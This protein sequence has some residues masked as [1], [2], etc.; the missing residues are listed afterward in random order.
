MVARR[1]PSRLVI[2]VLIALFTI[3]TISVA[4][5]AHA[6]TY[7]QRVLAIRAAALMGYWALNETSG[8]LAM[9]L[10][11]N[12]NNGTYQGTTLNGA[13][14][15]DGLSAPLF[16]GINDWVFIPNS[17]TLNPSGQL[18]ISVWVNATETTYWRGIVAKTD[19]A[20]WNTGYGIFLP[21]TGEINAY[22]T[23]YSNG[24]SANFSILSSW[25]HLAYTNDGFTQRLYQNGTLIAESG[26]VGGAS[27]TDDLY[28]GVQPGG[29]GW[30]GSI[31]RVALWNEAL[32]ADEIS[33]LADPSTTTIAPAANYTETLTLASGREVGLIY[34]FTVGEITVGLLVFAVLIVLMFRGRR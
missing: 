7:S 21:D 9:D 32:D 31:A 27:T 4:T 33:E 28:I 26:Y 34:T 11:G 5:P 29:A 22:L 24:I 19:G 20:T 18:T 3:S 6:L 23:G 2:W 16:D 25:V 13:I 14:H 8:S 10:S 12:G 15:P 1:R 30:Y 17:T